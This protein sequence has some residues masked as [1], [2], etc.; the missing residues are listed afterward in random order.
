MKI[1][2]IAIT[3]VTLIAISLFLYYEN[4][5]I[6]VTNIDFESKSLPK[7]FIG[8]KI[9]QISDLHSKLFGKNQKNLVGKIKKAKPD[10]IVITGD[11][12]D[13]KHYNEED[14]LKLIDEIKSISPI[15]FVTGNHESWSGKFLE[16]EGKLKDKGV[17]VLRNTN[18]KLEK[19]GE[20]ILIMGI[21][22]PEF[23]SNYENNGDS[24]IIEGFLEKA[25]DKED[26]S[27]FKIVLSHRPEQFS[28]YAKH[29]IDLTFS[30]HAHG[31]QIRLPIVG[32][33]IAPNQGLFPKYTSGIYYKDSSG[34]IVSRGLGNSIIPQR[35]FNRPEIIVTTLRSR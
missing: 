11:L 3:I 22:D 13:S 10:I 24:K 17:R 21:D 2:K 30:G 35:I 33:L 26:K 23:S 5:S 18:D 16:L 29:N 14:S 19:T 8:Y 31:G 20:N 15:Y 27:G 1:K 9:I 32:G 7:N 6:R 12:V 4:N 28:V 25:L 34:M